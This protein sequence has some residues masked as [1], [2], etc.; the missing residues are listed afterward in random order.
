MLSCEIIFNLKH[1]NMLQSLEIKN[2]LLKKNLKILGNKVRKNSIYHNIKHFNFK[3]DQ[4]LQKNIGLF[5]V[6]IKN[7]K[8]HNFQYYLHSL[9][10]KQKFL[11]YV[12]TYFFYDYLI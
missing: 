8:I 1:E 2:I 5:S 10:A 6:A 7:N 3:I 9:Q 11:P 4:P 12:T